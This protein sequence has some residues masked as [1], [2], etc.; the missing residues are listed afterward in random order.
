MR[1]PR[2]RIAATASLAALAT[3]VASL[4]G[5]ATALSIVPVA[6]SF[7]VRHDRTTVVPAPGVLGN[8]LNPEAVRL[9][10]A[11][12]RE[13]GEGTQPDDPRHETPPDLIELMRPQP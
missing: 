10:A 1:R 6:D 2:A 11:R 12:L 5:P 7:T 4:P 3:L 8:D 9:S 13:L